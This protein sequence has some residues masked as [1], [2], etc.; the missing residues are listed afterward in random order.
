MKLTPNNRPPPTQKL[1]TFLM[2]VKNLKNCS[3]VY[4]S[5]LTCPK[6]YAWSLPRV[7]RKV[8]LSNIPKL[9]AGNIKSFFINSS[10]CS[11]GVCS[12]SKVYSSQSALRKSFRSGIWKSSR[13]G[14]KNGCNYQNCDEKSS[15]I[16]TLHY[17]LFN[18]SLNPFGG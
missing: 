11:F 12:F 6:Q 1:Q 18:P 9:Q 5:I 16:M 8:R 17:E 3:K 2:Y 14:M 10:G 4:A 15:L 13:F 7:T